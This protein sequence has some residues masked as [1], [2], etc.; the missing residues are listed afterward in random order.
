MAGSSGRS[1]GGKGQLTYTGEELEV[2]CGRYFDHCDETGRKYTKPGL[3]LH[4]GL[5]E[6]TF[7]AWL[8]DEDGKYTEHSGVLKRAM[9]RMRDDLE[10]RNDTM[11]LFRL[12]QPCYSRYLDRPAEDGGQGLQVSVSFGKSDGKAT[13]AYGK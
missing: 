13:A 12:K 7:D 6:E 10:Q 3:V 4:L 2:L 8:R 9:I 5:P 1:K 11:S